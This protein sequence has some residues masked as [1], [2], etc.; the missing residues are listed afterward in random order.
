MSKL[1]EDRES[2]CPYEF[3]RGSASFVAK[4]NMK[5]VYAAILLVDKRKSQRAL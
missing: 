5:P 2:H 1:M 4:P 3:T